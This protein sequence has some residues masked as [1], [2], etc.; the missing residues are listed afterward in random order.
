VLDRLP[1]LPD[2][3]KDSLVGRF[4]NLQGLLHASVADL[5]DVEG[6]GRARA[7]PLPTYLDR[8]LDSSRGWGLEED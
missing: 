6:V 2:A 1:R 7:R 5:D 4:D 3:V 8:L